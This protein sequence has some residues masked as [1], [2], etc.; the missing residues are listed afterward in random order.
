MLQ[1]IDFIGVAKVDEIF[2][3]PAI[4]ENGVFGQAGLDVKVIEER[5]YILA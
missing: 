5:S 3:V 2:E 4:A 1:V